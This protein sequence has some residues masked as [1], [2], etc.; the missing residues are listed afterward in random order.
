[1]GG[2]ERERWQNPASFR[3]D[4]SGGKRYPL[5]LQAYQKKSDKNW[6][7]Q[8]TGR[9]LRNLETAYSAA[10]EKKRAEDLTRSRSPAAIFGA[11][12]KKAERG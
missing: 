2:L 5:F 11:F 3:R 7:F 8:L 4:G 9:P 1:M 6:T 10:G 12:S